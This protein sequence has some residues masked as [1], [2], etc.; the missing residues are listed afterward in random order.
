MIA[1]VMAAVVEGS[2]GGRRWAGTILR[3]F[4]TFAIAASSR[5]A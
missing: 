5:S 4:S 2:P 3:S 1:S